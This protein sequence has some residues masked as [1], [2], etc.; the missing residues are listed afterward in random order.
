MITQ[1][2]LIALMADLES[3]RIER[4][5]STNKTDKFCQAV[6]AFANDLPNHKQ[7]GYLVI[8]VDKHG[9]P[10]GIDVTE[11][12]LEKLGALRSDGNIQPLP[13]ISVAKIYLDS[14]DVAVV[15]VQ[16]SDLPPLRYKGQV[17]I[18]VGPRKATASEQEERI[19]TE[20]RISKARSYD[21]SPVGE[22]NLDDLSLA[23]FQAYRQEVVDAEVIAAN[24]RSVDDQ[25]ASLR[26]FDNRNHVPTVSGLLL[27]GKNPRYY[28]PGAYIQ[29][30]KLPGDSL[31]DRPDDQAEIS[32]DLLGVLR[33]LDARI[34]ANNQTWLEQTSALREKNVSDYPDVAIREILLN[35]VM[36]RDYQSNTPIKLYWFTDRIEIHSP[37]GLYGEVTPD[38][39]ERRSSYRNPVLAEAMKA[40]GY[41][42]RYGYGIQRA[43]SA[44]EKNGSD[45][46]HFE[47]DDRTFL[48]VLPGR[49]T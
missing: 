9:Q 3:D 32:G 44:M 23:Q 33:E 11:Q 6:C 31:T 36:H 25:L 38:T 8:G 20:K 49:A 29:Y 35:A 46:I 13:V 26:F 18:R 43:K 7:P 21:A 24:H 41:V 17:W 47:M 37:G 19:L 14:G 34:K 39:L 15:E 30:L 2:E 28:L 40:L 45:P 1:Q 27:F 10:T 12:L 16:P 42:N 22:A 48:A 4:T 5:E